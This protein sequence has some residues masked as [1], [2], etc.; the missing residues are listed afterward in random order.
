MALLTLGVCSPQELSAWNAR[1]E[2][3]FGHTFIVCATGRPAN[4]LLA[5]LR[6]RYPTAPHAELVRAAA[7]QAQ[8]TAL[9]LDKLVAALTA[10]AERR[11][12]AIEAHVVAPTSVA[13]PTR[14]PVTTHVLDLSRGGPAAGVPATLEVQE[15]GGWSVLGGGVTDVEGRCASLLSATHALRAGTY[16][17]TFDV[18]S[19]HASC[20]GTPGAAFYPSCAVT[21]CVTPAQVAQHFHIPLLLAPFGYSTYRGS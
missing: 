20:G 1:Y 21:F 9:R 15:R 16:R 3:K 17:I 18:A 5:L 12:G 11:T 8:I 2:A 14:P 10:R 19:Y 13:P 7:E 4:E 6:Q